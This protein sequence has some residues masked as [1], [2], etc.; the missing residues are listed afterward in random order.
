MWAGSD[1]D[2]A[3]PI[4][5]LLIIPVTIPLIQNIGIEIQKAKNMHKF[6]SWIY[7]FMAIGNVCL[8]IPLTK[9]YG[10]IGAAFG[11]AIS[12]LIG[13]GLI[14]NLY[15]HKRIGLDMKYFWSEIMRFIP[16]L[17]VPIIVGTL[18]V[19]FMDMNKFIVFL[20]CG[21]FYVII[22]CISMWFLGMNQYEKNLVGKPILK[23]IE[24]NKIK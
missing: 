22:F 11:T 18:M 15:Y 8:S 12:L 24:R 13:N 16:S 1:Y 14:M 21:I 2:D 7:L 20:I 10:G 6:R 9:L 3:Y 23:L 19:L 4:V 5:L 17:L